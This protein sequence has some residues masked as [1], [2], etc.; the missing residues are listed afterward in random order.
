L[1]K[2]VAPDVASGA[3]LI[4]QYEAQYK[5]KGLVWRIAENFEVEPGFIL[6]G[7]AIAAG[8]EK[9]PSSAL[10]QSTSSTRIQNGVTP[11][12]GLFWR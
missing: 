2:P 11:H 1:E 12:D 9:S 4:A 10:V 8:K 5:P 7:R 6:T 3:K